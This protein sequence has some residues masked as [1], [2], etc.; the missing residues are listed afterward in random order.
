MYIGFASEVILGYS[1]DGDKIFFNFLI[2]FY[3][4]YLYF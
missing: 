3:I 4:L 2:G 1:D